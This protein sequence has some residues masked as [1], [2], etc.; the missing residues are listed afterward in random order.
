MVIG[1]GIITRKLLFAVLLV[2]SMSLFGI[3]AASAADVGTAPTQTG[4]HHIVN[5]ITKVH[6]K[7]FKDVKK[8]TKTQKRVA[9]KL[10]VVKKTANS[11]KLSTQNVNL[12]M[13]VAKRESYRHY[14]HYRHYKYYGKY[15]KTHRHY[16]YHGKYRTGHAYKVVRSTGANSS[17]FGSLAHSITGNTS[18]QYLKGARI[19]NWVK[20]HVRYSFYSNTRKGALGTLRYRSGNCADQTHL[21]VALARSSGLQARYVH[22]KAHF[23]SGHWYGH[24]WAQIKTNGRWITADT[25][26][27]RNSF[28]VVRNWNSARIQGIYNNLPF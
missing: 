11:K 1:G 27:K 23:R 9:K 13:S 17:S 16:R 2:A 19:F 12:N 22:A 21:V 15:K 5:K 25:T 8:S 7:H 20:T 4:N 28:G 10:K 24:V 26:S 3:A 6:V 18:S 14:K